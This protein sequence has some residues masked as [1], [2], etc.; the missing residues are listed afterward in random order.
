MYLLPDLE[1]YNSPV[2]EMQAKFK[3]VE[4][5]GIPTNHLE[6]SG[7]VDYPLAH[8]DQQESYARTHMGTSF[9]DLSN[10]LFW[11]ILILFG[12][13]AFI[14]IVVIRSITLPVNQPKKPCSTWAKGFTRPP[15]PSIQRR[16]RRHGLCSQPLGRRPAQ[17]LRVLQLCW[18]RAI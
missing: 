9:Y 8:F 13:G 14:A 10:L 16:N 1:S 4:G 5:E 2:V 7:H 17:N 3:L 12:S 18:T 15:H 11:L 6:F